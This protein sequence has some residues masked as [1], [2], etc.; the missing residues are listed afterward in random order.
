MTATLRYRAKWI[1]VHL[2][3]VTGILSLWAS[4]ALRRR[5]VVLMYHRVLPKESLTHTWSHPAIIVTCDTFDRHM[6]YVRE[7]F[8]VVSASEFQSCLEAGGTFQKASC[9]VTFDDGWID[10][11]THAFPILRRHRIPALVFL[12]SAYIGTGQVFWQERL[13]AL[14]FELWHLARNDEQFAALARPRLAEFGLASILDVEE[15]DVRREIIT[16][17]RRRKEGHLDDPFA[18]VRALSPLVGSNAVSDNLDQF[19]NWDQVQA[20]RQAGIAFGAHGDSHRQLTAVTGVDLRREV[21]VSREVLQ[22][23]TGEAPATFSYPNGDWNPAVAEEVRRH[24]FAIAFATR[25]GRV[26]TDADRFAVG[27]INIHEAAANSVPLF[28]AKIVGIIR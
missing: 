8:R 5:A 25:P 14:L 18:P 23:S 1:L 9:L 13:G 10:T 15:A 20:M 4:V 24:S 19:M 27:R 16:V 26:G 12:P 2:L 7:R 28:L 17:V 22:A 21:Q 11:Y 3:Y 6:Q